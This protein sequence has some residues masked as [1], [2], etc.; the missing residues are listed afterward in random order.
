MELV[1]NRQGY[2]VSDTHRE[3][4]KCSKVYRITS[5]NV[6]YCKECNCNRVKSYSTEYKML[7][8]AKVRAKSSGIKCSI[9]VED[10]HIPEI[11]PILGVRLEV[12][13]GSAGGKPYS[14][15]LDRIDNSKGYEPGNVVVISHLANMMKSS[16]NPEQL[17][18]FAKWVLTNYTR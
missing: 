6:R 9:R 4:V 3:C 14:P 17:V 1:K 11:C 2:M 13:S 5:T 10:I 8:R 18:L 7:A 16:A 12:H 15:S